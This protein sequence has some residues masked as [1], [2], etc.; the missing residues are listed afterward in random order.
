MSNFC[1]CCLE[2]WQCYILSICLIIW[3]RMFSHNSVIIY[4]FNWTYI[5]ILHHMWYLAVGKALTVLIADHTVLKPWFTV[6]WGSRIKHKVNWI[7]EYTMHIQIYIPIDWRFRHNNVF[8]SIFFWM[9]D[10]FQVKFRNL[11]YYKS[12]LCSSATKHEGGVE[13]R[14]AIVCSKLIKL[15]WDNAYRL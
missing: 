2:G 10:N 4:C 13:V 3:Y 8:K 14:V 9:C 5:V 12:D 6:F 1:T 11:V 7:V 15:Q